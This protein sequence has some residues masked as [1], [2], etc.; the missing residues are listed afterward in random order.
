MSFFHTQKQPPAKRPGEKKE[1][2]AIEVAEVAR[3]RALA[4][5]P[6]TFEGRH[7]IAYLQDRLTTYMDL[8]RFDPTCSIERNGL[9]N[10]HTGGGI[11]ELKRILE[12]IKN[13]NLLAVEITEGEK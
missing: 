13:G 8:P 12:T 9:D 5:L 7:L 2:N 6:D 10:A 4:S 1:L 11:Y 3:L